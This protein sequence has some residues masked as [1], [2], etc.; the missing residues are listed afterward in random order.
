M[1]N[2]QSQLGGGGPPAN[3]YGFQVLRNISPTLNLDPFFDFIVGING[4]PI[5]DPNPNLFLQE[6]YNCAGSVLR[7]GVWSGKGGRLR[8]VDVDLTQPKLDGFGLT[9]DGRVQL[10]LSVQWT[11]LSVAGNVWRIL[12]VQENS[13]A[14][15]AGLIEEEDF[16]VGTPEGIVHGENGMSALIQ[17]FQDRPLRLYV[18]NHPTNTTRELTITPHRNWGGDGLLGCVLGFGHLHKLPA[19]LEE[20]VEAPGETLFDSAFQSPA[21][22]NYPQ[23]QF[24]TFSP[25]SGQGYPPPSHTPQGGYSSGGN[26]GFSPVPFVGNEGF[27]TAASLAPPPPPM[28]SSQGEV[29]VRSKA[30]KKTGH[31]GAVDMDAYLRE[32]EE[33]SKELDVHVGGAK[34][35]EGAPPPPKGIP[36]PPKKG[37]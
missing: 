21:T 18:H 33:K 6:V 36:P 32:G 37:D 17:D 3:S 12:R 26:D 7:L 13:P 25:V 29:A 5:E 35:G 31:R 16:I 8:D 2:E 27:V 14:D 30:K 19:P 28:A 4:R 10:G 11:P 1:G 20:A 9:H 15:L 23:Q 34:A 24:T 22:P